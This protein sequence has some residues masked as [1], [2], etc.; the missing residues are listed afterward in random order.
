MATTVMGVVHKIIS[1]YE[2]FY[3]RNRR[4]HSTRNCLTLFGAKNERFCPDSLLPGI[5]NTG[6]MSCQGQVHI[7][8]PASRIMIGLHS[9]PTSQGLMRYISALQCA[10]WHLMESGS[11]LRLT[12]V[13]NIPGRSSDLHI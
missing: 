1:F 6:G 3:E 9:S 13:S 10:I 8:P 5:R 11:N 4:E 12:L 7:T 2:N